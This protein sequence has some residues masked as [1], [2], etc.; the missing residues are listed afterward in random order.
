MSLVLQVADG[1]RIPSSLLEG[2]SESPSPQSTQHLGSHPSPHVSFLPS[3]TSMGDITLLQ[4]H[5]GSLG[6]RSLPKAHGWWPEQS[7]VL[8]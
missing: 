6:V 5:K 4:P 8:E 7:H 1:A 3:L 2:K